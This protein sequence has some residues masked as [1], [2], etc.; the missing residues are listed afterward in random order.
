MAII[1]N[2]NNSLRTQARSQY[3]V[4]RVAK[5]IFCLAYA[6]DKPGIVPS[7]GKISF[8]PT[9]K[10]AQV[11]SIVVNTTSLSGA[12][13]KDFYN[14]Y[15]EG[16]ITF[17]D[18][19]LADNFATFKVGSR[20]MSDDEKTVTFTVPQVLASDAISIFKQN[21]QVC[22]VMGPAPT[23]EAFITIDGGYFGTPA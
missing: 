6:V 3:A 15:T 5:S 12:N 2:T 1:K 21:M 4:D 22:L 18:K 13:L 14:F 19:P 7:E 9:N 17:H 8:S 20:T 11:T 10:P 23:S 16:S